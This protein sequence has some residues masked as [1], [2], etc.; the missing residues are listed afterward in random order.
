VRSFD[1]LETLTAIIGVDPIP[2]ICPTWYAVMQAVSTLP[3][4]AV[5]IITRGR[6]LRAVFPKPA[7]S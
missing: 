5:A 1:R 7:K 4:I 6:L 3:L 2:G